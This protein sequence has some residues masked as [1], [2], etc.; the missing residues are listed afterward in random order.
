MKKLLFSLVLLLSPLCVT[1]YHGHGHSFGAGFGGGLL[2]G[3]VGSALVSGGRS[4]TVYVQQPTPQPVVVQNDAALERVRR[5]NE[6]LRRE[7]R[8]LREELRKK[9]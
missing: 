2:G 7:M 9:K 3:V 8:E 1:A 4:D 5:E 6:E